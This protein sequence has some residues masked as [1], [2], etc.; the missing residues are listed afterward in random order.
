MLY[1]RS[2]DSLLTTSGKVCTKIYQHPH[3]IFET[4]ESGHAPDLFLFRSR[5]LLPF[6]RFCCSLPT[7]F[8]IFA[9]NLQGAY[10]KTK[11]DHSL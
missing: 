4:E 8:S 10:E 2:L 9:D 6:I 11:W 3:L 7:I 1:G 5:Y